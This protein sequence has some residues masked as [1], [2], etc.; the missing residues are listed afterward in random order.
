M[1]AK[2]KTATPHLDAYGDQLPSGALA[3][4]G[5]L[6]FRFGTDIVRPAFSVDGKWI[7]VSDEQ[8]FVRIIQ[9]AT[10]K[11]FRKFHVEDSRFPDLRFLPDGKCLVGAGSIGHMEV[12]DPFLGRSIRQLENVH[13]TG[14]GGPVLSGD[15]KTLA[16]PMAD[17][18]RVPMV[19]VCQIGTGKELARIPLPYNRDIRVALS[20]DGKLLAS[21]G[22]DGTGRHKKKTEAILLWNVPTARVLRQIK[23]GYLAEGIAF[24]PDGNTLA[25]AVFDGRIDFWNVNTGKLVRRVAALKEMGDLLVYSPDGKTLAAGDYNGRI[26]IWDVPSG[27]RLGLVETGERE[28]VSLAFPGRGK[29]LACQ[30]HGQAISVWDVLNETE[31]SPPAVHKAAIKALAF[32]KNDRKIY[33]G[34]T[35]GFVNVWQTTNGKLM[36]QVDVRHEDPHYRG[37]GLGWLVFSAHGRYLATSGHSDDRMNIWDM[38]KGKIVCQMEGPKNSYPYWTNVVFSAG[39]S[40]MASTGKTGAIVLWNIATGERLRQFDASRGTAGCLAFGPGGKTLAAAIHLGESSGGYPPGG[41]P[42]HVWD[43]ATGKQQWKTE[44]PDRGTD[45]LAFSPDGSLL[46]GAGVDGLYLWDAVTGKELSRLE[47]DNP[48]I[49]SPV[50]S[51][52]NRLLA[53]ATWDQSQD[54]STICLW[55]VASGTVRISF[56]GHRG[57]TNVL[58]FSSDGGM[59]ASAAED[60]T[61]ML[62]GIAARQKPFKVRRVPLA[63]KEMEGIWAQLALPNAAKAYPAFCTLIESPG[64]ALRLFTKRLIPDPGIDQKNLDHLIGDLDSNRFAIRQAAI[65]KLENMDDSTHPTFRMVLAS[66]PSLEVAKRLERVLKKTRYPLASGNV[67]RQLR[68]LEV[69]ERIGTAEAQRLLKRLSQGAAEARQT[70]EA[71]VI[72]ARLAARP[73]R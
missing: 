24:S 39:E 2:S 64:D 51:P 68:A 14:Q 52:D 37:Q 55:E 20:V 62:W 11:A 54:E 5:T 22:W 72:L 21:T 23:T 53:A 60:T 13:E 28:F 29:V 8:G 18:K 42:I 26:Q 69:L 3:R 66:K 43:T 61:V 49:C 73:S 4:L 6:R 45:T 9:V 65:R 67:L 19:V 16:I 40:L 1:T 44:Q 33:S 48:V 47:S 63:A 58:A 15:G 34:D 31:L 56:Q 35:R 27:K 38:G 17:S 30:G 7:A 10:G 36:R 57:R 59:L 50:F 32:G 12:W 71:R 70:R 46:A 25:S 41:G